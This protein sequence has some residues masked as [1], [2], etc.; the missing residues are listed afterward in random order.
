ME[1]PLPISV[2]IV[3]CNAEQSLR[4]CLA[5]AR[6]LAAEIVVVDSGSTDGSRGVVDEFGGRWLEQ[7]WL[8]FRDQKNVALDHCTQPWVLAL[9]SDEELSEEL[10]ASIRAFL[11]EQDLRTS[12]RWILCAQGLVSGTLGFGT[13]D[14]YPDYKL[15]L[16]RRASGRWGGSPEHDKVILEG[17]QVKLEGDLHHYS[18]PSINRYIDKINVF[19]DEYLKRQIASGTRWSLLHNL[20]RPV[21]RFVRCYIIR[22]GFLDGFPGLWIATGIAFQTFVR[23][24][25]TYE[26]HVPANSGNSSE[27]QNG[28]RP[29]AAAIN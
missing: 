3:T 14:W 12:R 1:R 2:S 29:G 9:D 10:R 7:E 25:R 13:E 4:R 18:F 22:R 11:R 16:F 15:R 28:R 6:G 23:H 24:S 26:H 8:G 21:W 27:E 5:S 19:S 17:T 20:F